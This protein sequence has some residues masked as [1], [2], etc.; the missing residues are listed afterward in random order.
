MKKKVK[1]QIS[2]N[3][4]KMKIS[5]PIYLSLYISSFLSLSLTYDEEVEI[6]K[7]LLPSHFL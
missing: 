6:S 7:Y 5:L 3:A 2:M 1:S 4:S